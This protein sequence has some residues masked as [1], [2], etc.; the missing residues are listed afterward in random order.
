[1]PYNWKCHLG[2][3]LPPA[4]VVGYGHPPACPVCLRENPGQG[5][6]PFTMVPTQEPPTEEEK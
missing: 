4:A 6:E 3:V 1:M 2:H 5:V